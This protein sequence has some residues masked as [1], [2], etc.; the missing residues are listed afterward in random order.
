MGTRGG[1]ARL[2]VRPGRMVLHQEQDG[3]HSCSPGASKGAA[4]AGR[5]TL[6]LPTVF[7]TSL[8]DNSCG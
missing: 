3:L 5:Q 8:I 7:M 1:K 2:M 4:L 6:K